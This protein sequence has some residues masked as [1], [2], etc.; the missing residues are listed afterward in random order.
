VRRSAGSALSALLALALVPAASAQVP[1]A[2]PNV[3][4]SCDLL[5]AA[6]VHLADRADGCFGSLT[7]DD[8]DTDGKWVTWSSGD[9]DRAM[10]LN[11]LDFVGTAY[12]EWNQGAAA[13]DTATLYLSGSVTDY[14]GGTLTLSNT[15]VDLERETDDGEVVDDRLLTNGLAFTPS[16]LD[17]LAP[18][19]RPPNAPADWFWRGP[20]VTIDL[21]RGGAV[22]GYRAT[23]EVSNTGAMELYG[24]TFR[25]TRQVEDTKAWGD[26][27]WILRLGEDNG[28]SAFVQGRGPGAAYVSNGCLTTAGS[29]GCATTAE[30]PGV[31][32]VTTPWSW[33]GNAQ[34]GIPT[35]TGVDARLPV[36]MHGYDGKLLW[37]GLR[38][39]VSMLDAGSKLSLEALAPGLELDRCQAVSGQAGASRSTVVDGGTVTWLAPPALESGAPQ[40]RGRVRLTLGEAKV[41][42]G[43]RLVDSGY[44]ATTLEGDAVYPDAGGLLRVVGRLN[45]YGYDFAPV[46][47]TWDPSTNQ[48][49]LRMQKK[50][51]FGGGYSVDGDYHGVWDR[52][53]LDLS[54]ETEQDCRWIGG[55]WKTLQCFDVVH[56]AEVCYAGRCVQGKALMSSFVVGGCAT[57]DVRFGIGGGQVFQV[58]RGVDM[59]WRGR[60]VNHMPSDCGLFSWGP[61]RNSQSTR[62]AQA[63]PAPFDFPEARTPMA[64]RV[65]G[66]GGAPKVALIGPDGQRVDPPA[67]GVDLTGGRHVYTEDEPASTTT[68]I[69]VPGK[70]GPWRVEPAPGSARPVRVE[71]ARPAT[72]P[73]IHGTVVGTGHRR[74]LRYAVAADRRLRVGIYEQSRTR[75]RLLGYA[76]GGRCAERRRHHQHPVRCGVI[77]FSPLDDHQHDRRIVARV[78]AGA[79]HRPVGSFTFARY[80][81]PPPRALPRPR[82]VRVR[83]QGRT[84]RISWARVPRAANYVVHAATGHGHGSDHMVGHRRRSYVLRG[85]SPHAAVHVSVRA[86]GHDGRTGRP[87]SATSRGR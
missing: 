45:M 25:I 39:G 15:T 49:A 55:W 75:R 28:T 32:C 1:S 58:Y 51:D 41:H 8:R 11:G 82:T 20:K 76:R 84:V 34:I 7:L 17:A 6:A 61:T 30:T 16:H 47:L 52:N 36:W 79:H 27:R 80:Q 2:H 9:D 59:D 42:D 60:G 43:S 62:A 81:A 44:P 5:V 4:T 53:F 12:A 71:V 19:T 13:T 86:R 74:E 66:E 64:V 63:G 48:V 3:Q 24:A 77:R 67:N 40:L 69:L 85:V 72:E 54:T 38:D 83:R 23:A 22:T 21:E 31:A 68:I 87:R 26:D 18:S 33:G 65:H 46:H 35:A 14:A 78:D 37:M 73:D 29:L 56:K 10:S 57:F 70:A 50:F